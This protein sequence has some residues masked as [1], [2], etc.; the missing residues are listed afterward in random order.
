MSLINCPE[1][2]KEISD[3]AVTCIN[4]GYK[5]KVISHKSKKVLII[6][7]ITIVLIL[8][9]V[10][11]Y[12]Q[13]QNEQL[14]IQQANDTIDEFND[15]KEK[16]DELIDKWN[17]TLDDKYLDEAKYYLKRMKSLSVQ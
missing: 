17:E 4:C 15:A 14:F 9:I 5:L 10:I 1:C 12:N 6:G 3:S 13:Y 8:G 11:I 16:Y 7:I 2:Q